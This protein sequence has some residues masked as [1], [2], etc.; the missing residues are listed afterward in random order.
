MFLMTFSKFQ[1]G[2]TLLGNEKYD[3]T[4]AGSDKFANSFVD[5]SNDG[6]LMVW[7]GKINNPTDSLGFIKVYD[8]D[9]VLPAQEEILSKS[10]SIYPNPS[11]SN[12]HISIDNIGDYK[13]TLFDATGKLIKA[14]NYQSEGA[15]ISLEDCENCIYLLNIFDRK[16]ET[17]VSKKIVKLK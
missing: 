16:N 12:I 14:F 3:G 11:R 13:L 5:I 7:G 2:N 8:Y 10:I 17:F 1:L 4:R 9:M 6:S 15:S